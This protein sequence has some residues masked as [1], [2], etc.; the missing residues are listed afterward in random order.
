MDPC[1]RV[2]FELLEMIS[3]PCG[4]REWQW[5]LLVLAC[6][7]AG[8]AFPAEA[9]PMRPSMFLEWMRAPD[10]CDDFIEPDLGTTHQL[11]FATLQR[12]VGNLILRRTERALIE[13]CHARLSHCPMPDCR[14]AGDRCLGVGYGLGMILGKDLNRARRHFDA[15]A[16]RG[17]AW[18]ARQAAAVTWHMGS[19]ERAAFYQRLEALANGTDP[20]AARA[21]GRIAMEG[22]TPPDLVQAQIW[23]DKAARMGDLLGICA[24]GALLATGPPRLRDDARSLALFVRVA[25]SGNADAIA[26]I[27]LFYEL[28]RGVKSDVALAKK[29]HVRAAEAG[30]V[31][32]RRNLAIALEH[33]VGGESDPRRALSLYWSAAMEGDIF[34]REKLRLNPFARGAGK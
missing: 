1:G 5:I 22:V 3:A 20:V 10:R 12:P 2:F 33:G 17:D 23:Y 27:G 31:P 13:V 4:F 14:S 34:S 32:G 26:N 9:L 21:R 11:E 24:Q 8:A 16:R 29:L 25:D 18:S 15:A 19:I 6:L 28:G 7:W 30:S